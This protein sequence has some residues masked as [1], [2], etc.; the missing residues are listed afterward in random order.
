MDEPKS[1]CVICKKKNPSSIK[2]NTEKRKRDNVSK[3]L[4]NLLLT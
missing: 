4:I 2:E 1:G 3:I